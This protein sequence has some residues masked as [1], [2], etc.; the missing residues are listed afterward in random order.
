ME[1]DDTTQSPGLRLRGLRKSFGEV[2]AVAGLDLDVPEGAICALLGPSGCGKTTTLRLIA[3]LERPDAGT[4][5]I[6]GEEVAGPGRT[7]PAERRRI[8]MV[9]QDYALFPH[10]DVAA[11][12]GYAL[13]RRPD[14]AKVASALET[15]GL[16]GLGKRNPHELS[17]G[18]QQRVALAR[19]LVAE[20]RALLLDEPFSNLDAG[21][22]ARVRE[23]VREILAEQQLTSVFVTHD[24]EEALSVADVVAVVNE[25]K[26]EQVGTPEDVYSRPS[27]R[28]V[29]GFLGE[30]EVLPGKAVNGTVECE[31]GPLPNRNGLKGDVDVLVRPESLAIGTIEPPDKRSQKATV[32]SRSFFGHDQLV[33][34]ELPSGSIVKVRRLGFPAWHPGDHV[35]IWIEGPADVI[36]R[37]A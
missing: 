6:G 19:A 27:T 31:L 26:V 36:A 15:V 34:L 24:Q 30:I 23:E 18:Q 21:L 8:G 17:G 7:V 25:G 14:P 28:W 4:V 22:R 37:D 29:A 16:G 33:E 3:G 20:P 1:Y 13:G 32:V 35:R 5:E 12:V 10:M 11:N 2:E 9:F